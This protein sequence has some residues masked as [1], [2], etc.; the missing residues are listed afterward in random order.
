VLSDYL[1]QIRTLLDSYARAAFVLDVS[2]NFEARPGDQA[3]MAGVMTF[4]DSSELHFA[5]F[6]DATSRTVEKLMCRYYY[7]DPTGQTV[8][9][10]DNARHRPPLL[11]LSHKHT[12][13]QIE[14]GA[15]PALE[16]VLGEIVEILCAE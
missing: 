1:A 8:F 13:G 5:E 7:Q 6:L 2:V 12:S 10:Y 14:I 16:D 11:S 4:V 3:Y 9:R 15:V